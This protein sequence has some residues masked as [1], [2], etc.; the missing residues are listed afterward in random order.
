MSRLYLSIL[1]EAQKHLWEKLEPVSQ[2]GFTLYG[3]TALALQLNH[4]RSLDFDFFSSKPLQF[5]RILDAL[6]NPDTLEI[7]K[8]EERTLELIT[9]SG[10]HLS[11]FG[12]LS[13]RRVGNPIWVEE[14][15]LKIASLDDLMA[16]KLKVLFQRIECKDYMDLA[17]MLRH[18]L[19]LS[20]GLSDAVAIY[21]NTFQP[22]IALKSM[23]Y[24]EGGDLVDLPERDKETLLR[25]AQEVVSWECHNPDAYD[26]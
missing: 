19:S 15:H 2:M 23:T 12:A 13:M 20:K 3:G 21:G 24:F 9:Q 22:I 5:Q 18:G 26:L 10:V 16:A 25:A 14:N 17:E 7:V 6:P 4:R 1:S 8:S 11:F